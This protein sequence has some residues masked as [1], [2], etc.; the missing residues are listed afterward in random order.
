MSDK[1]K[2]HFNGQLD[3]DQGQFEPNEKNYSE[4]QWE[5]AHKLYFYFYDFVNDGGISDY[6][7]ARY[8]WAAPRQFLES[9]KKTFNKD[10]K[11][12]EE[13]LSDTD[14]E[15]E[16]LAQ[17]AKAEKMNDKEKKMLRMSTKQKSI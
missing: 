13:V 14:E 15:N 10:T 5:D 16:R 3:F 8:L 6:E 12:K 7:Q 11:E 17:K 4:E 1:S 9:W 2:F